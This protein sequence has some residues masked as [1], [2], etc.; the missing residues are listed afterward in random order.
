VGVETGSTLVQDTS[1]GREAGQQVTH[2]VQLRGLAGIP[3]RHP[4]PASAWSGEELRTPTCFARI[5]TPAR[6]G[7]EIAPLLST[8]P[9]TFPS[10]W[11]SAP[12]SFFWSCCRSS[13]APP[14]R[15]SPPPRRMR[16]SR[17]A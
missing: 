2:R 12:A 10:C 7:T 9:R 17:P 8:I 6:L 5:L 4:G 1:V 11:A 13:P 15:M 14:W 3:A 16:S